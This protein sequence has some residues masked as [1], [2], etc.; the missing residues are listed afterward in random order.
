MFTT[1]LVFGGLASTILLKFKGTAEGGLKQLN[2]KE[3]LPTSELSLQF[4]LE[5]ESRCLKELGVPLKL[6]FLLYP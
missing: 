1:Q 4:S 2:F 3:C 5:I 6:C